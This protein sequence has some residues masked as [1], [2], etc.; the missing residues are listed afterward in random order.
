MPEGL[1]GGTSKLLQMARSECRCAIAF[2]A[3]EHGEE[4]FVAA[5]PAP[6][7]GDALDPEAVDGLVRQVW[8]DPE[9]GRARAVVRTTRLARPGSGGPQ[10]LVL[11]VVPLGDGATG[12][13]S[14]MLGAVGPEGGRSAHRSWRASTGWGGDWRRTSRRAMRSGRSPP[15]GPLARPSGPH[16]RSPACCTGRA[17]GSRRQRVP[18]GTTTSGPT[19]TVGRRRLPT[20]VR[21]DPT[22]ERPVEG[23]RRSVLVA[24]RHPQATPTMTGEV[25]TCRGI[26]VP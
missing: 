25:T 22:G 20:P 13:P 12:R 15:S 4:V 7:A 16:R 5:D 23:K 18:T 2:V 6:T 9:F 10:R 24:R 19:A 21:V 8:S 26:L 14:G 1:N 17:L 11:A 3:L